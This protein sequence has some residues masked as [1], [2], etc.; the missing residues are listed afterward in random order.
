M[1]NL[2]SPAPLLHKCVEERVNT[3]EISLHEPAVRA[4]GVSIF[5]LDGAARFL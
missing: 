3:Q 1:E 4:D 2:L 5:G